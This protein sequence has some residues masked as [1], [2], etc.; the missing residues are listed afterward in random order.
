[1]AKYLQYDLD[2]YGVD[3]TIPLTRGD[4]WTLVGRIFNLNG[5]NQ[6]RVDITGNEGATAFFPAA[7][8]TLIVGNISVTDPLVGLLTI[9]LPASGTLLTLLNDTGVSNYITL[10]DENGLLE[11]INTIDQ[12]LKIQDRAFGQI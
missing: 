4:D 6:E 7:D 9:T 10:L 3:N 12:A 8:G 5:A 2:Q 1:M 11:T